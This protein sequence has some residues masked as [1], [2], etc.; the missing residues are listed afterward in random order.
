MA[1]AND[2]YHW[3][4]L[5]VKRSGRRS[6]LELTTLAEEET[7]IGNHISSNLLHDLIQNLMNLQIDFNAVCDIVQHIKDPSLD[8]LE[9]FIASH[10][11]FSN[12]STDIRRL[13]ATFLYR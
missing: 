5:W 12:W 11:D 3:V 13:L 4:K 7:A 8:Q 10:P 6:F 1:S 2:E 9:V